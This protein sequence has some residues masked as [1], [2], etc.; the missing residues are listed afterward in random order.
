MILTCIDL[1]L[2]WLSHRSWSNVSLQRGSWRT[3]MIIRCL[4]RVN[5]PTVASTRLIRPSPPYTTILY[6]LRRPTKLRR[7][8][9]LILLVPWTKSTEL[10]WSRKHARLNKLVNMEQTVTVGARVIRPTAAVWDLGILLDQE[11]SMTQHIAWVTSS[12]FYQLRC[13]IRRP[14]GQEL[15]AQLVHSFDLSRLD[16]FVLSRL[17]YGNSVF[18][19]MPKSTINAFRNAEVRLILDL[20]MNEHG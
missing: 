1:S 18:A 2:I 7:S 6:E 20:R 9:Y 4:P 3:S 12:G 8:C 5:R 19:S 11:L 14:V 13:K 15:V 17:D 16:L 10:A